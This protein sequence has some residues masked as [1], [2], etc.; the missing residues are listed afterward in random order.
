MTIRKSISVR[1]PPDRAFTVFT[2]E[3]GRWWPLKRGFSF[4]RERA[5]EIFLEDRIGGRFYE[6]FSDGTE[7]E[8]GRV[9]HCEPP[10][11]IVFGFTSPDWDAP[12]E[13][14]VRFAAEPDGTR[15][16]L[17]HRGFDAS[18]KM[19]ERGKGFAG[20]WDIVLAQYLAQ[21]NR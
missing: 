9:M 2:R 20:G 7:S 1:C 13:V 5:N 4:D 12:T 11:L 18:P 17:E 19:R 16:D 3:I 10:L 6:R 8:I 15:V 21:A 14:E